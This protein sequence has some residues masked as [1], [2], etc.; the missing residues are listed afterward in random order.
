[1]EARLELLEEVQNEAE[2]E[3]AEEEGLQVSGCS[4]LLVILIFEGKASIHIN[5]NNRGR[6]IVMKF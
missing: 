5:N 4:P 6:G 1:M 2:G 3:E